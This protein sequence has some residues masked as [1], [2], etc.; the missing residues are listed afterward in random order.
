MEATI[1]GARIH[2]ERAGEGL[3]VVFL[4]AGIAD[5]RMWAPQLEEFVKHFDVICPD[6]RGFGRSELPPVRWSEPS[7]P[8]SLVHHLLLDD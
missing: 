2:Y 1:N 3:P 6:S 8:L 5:S 4:H 7:D